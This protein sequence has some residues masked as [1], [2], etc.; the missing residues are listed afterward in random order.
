MYLRNIFFLQYY[1]IFQDLIR[2]FVFVS[3]KKSVTEIDGSP[4]L[5]PSSP[6]IRSYTASQ[7]DNKDSA[8]EFSTIAL[9][10][11]WHKLTFAEIEHCNGNTEDCPKDEYDDDKIE[12]NAKKNNKLELFKSLSSAESWESEEDCPPLASED[13]DLGDPGEFES[14]S[15]T[16]DEDEEEDN[17][18]MTV[19]T[20]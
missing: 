11:Y 7:L 12:N 1:A 16:E 17:V 2:N 8:S 13:S 10:K 15:G 5:T 9:N 4:P 18:S 14:F 6:F 19:S 3:D 20:K